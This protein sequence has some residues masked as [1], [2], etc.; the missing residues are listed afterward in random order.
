M[1]SKMSF[2]ITHTIK[3]VSG[4]T[5]DLGPTETHFD[6]PW[7]VKANKRDND[8]LDLYFNCCLNN[9][10]NMWSVLAEFQFKLKSKTGEDS[11]GQIVMKLPKLVEEFVV[12]NQLT[13]ECHVTIK[14]IVGISQRRKMDWEAPEERM[15]DLVMV[16]G[17]EKTKFHVHRVTLANFSPVFKAMF[18]NPQFRESSDKE[19]ILEDVDPDAF[20]VLINYIHRCDTDITD[21]NVERILVLADRFD[22][23]VMLKKCEKYLMKKSKFGMEKLLKL[24]ETYQLVDLH[25]FCLDAL[26]T[27]K[28]I[29]NV[30]QNIDEM[31]EHTSKA[32]LKKMKD[33]VE[34]TELYT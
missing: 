16:V 29:A 4:L 14:D 20:K 13:F 10:S 22:V 26:K 8:N 3:N 28:Q 5:T 23:S 11:R 17:E 2:I 25:G 27:T 19:V 34:K 1:E 32:L 30:C 21:K 9:S 15:T 31:G 7:R 33:I 12:D 6:I 18:T 24:A